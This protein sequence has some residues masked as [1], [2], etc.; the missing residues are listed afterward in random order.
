MDV[1]QALIRDR[2]AVA[3]SQETGCDLEHCVVLIRKFDDFQKVGIL[4]V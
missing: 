4:L 2:V 1:V 3:S